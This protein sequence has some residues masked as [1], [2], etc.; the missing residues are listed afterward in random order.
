MPYE[1]TFNAQ[2]PAPDQPGASTGPVDSAPIYRLTLWPHQSLPRVGFVWFIG[3]TAALST[4]P[5]LAVLGSPVMWGL[6]PFILLALAAIWWGL[7]RSY[8]DGEI[9]ESMAIWPDRM[10]LVRSG[11]RGAHAEWT[12]NPYWV[13]TALHV[14]GGRVPNYIT[15][16]GGDREV[17]LGAFLSEEERIAL[18][19]DLDEALRSLRWVDTLANL[20]TTTNCNI[21]TTTRMSRKSG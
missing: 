3:A 9:I 5:L 15:L 17:E 4:L 10:T 12:A 2:Q 1:L 19:S 13:T 20:R 14:T 8:R 6:V 11:P 7:S 21:S 16:R 18:R